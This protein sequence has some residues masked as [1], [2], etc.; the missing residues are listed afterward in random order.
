MLV[1]TSFIIDVMMNDGGAVRKA[2]ELA[3]ASISLMVGTPTVFEL[4]VGVGLSV[5]SHEEREKILDI[6]KSLAHLSLDTPSA[7]RAGL[8]YAQRAKEGMKIDPEDAML[9]GIA[10]ENHQPLLTRNRKDFAGI[11]ELRVESY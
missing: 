1:D 8:V 3:D 11:P 4:Y 6:L 5:K 10:I 9:A 7:S 2:K